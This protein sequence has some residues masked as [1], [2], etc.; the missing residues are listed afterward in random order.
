MPDQL[1]RDELM[2]ELCRR[3]GV[4]FV[5]AG[6]AGAGDAGERIVVSTW[7]FD[8][9]PSDPPADLNRL[10]PFEDRPEIGQAMVELRPLVISLPFEDGEEAHILRVLRGQTT[11]GKL[12]RYVEEV[13]SGTFDDVAANHGPAAFFLGIE[14]PD[15][16]V[17]ISVWTSWESIEA[18]TGSNVREPSSTRHEQQL[19]AA[20]IVHYEIVPNTVAGHASAGGDGR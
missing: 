10:F 15:G 5:Y 1:L 9:P 4:Q 13:R 6:R 7:E 20:D 17:T 11:P 3:A 16:F 12:D 19:V 18:A 14:P 2:P 8:T